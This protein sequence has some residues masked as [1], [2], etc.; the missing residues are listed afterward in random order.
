[1]SS[2]IK[3]ARQ[4]GHEDDKTPKA[5]CDEML[6]Q[7]YLQSTHNLHIR[8]TLDQFFY[9]GIDTTE[10]D[11][12]QVVYRYLKDRNK[13]RKVFMVDQ[14]WLWIIGKGLCRPTQ[15]ISRRPP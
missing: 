2:A 11:V 9:H 10:R 12:D 1:M 13:E 15:L 4:G 5:S 3:K 8:R 7:A 14:L 6:V